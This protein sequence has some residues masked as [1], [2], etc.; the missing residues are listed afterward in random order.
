MTAILSRPQCVEL[1]IRC[2]DD[3]PVCYRRGGPAPLNFSSE[4]PARS[5]RWYDIRIKEPSHRD[6]NVIR[7]MILV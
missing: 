1:N 3:S 2:Q 6:Q 4:S 7:D 5:S